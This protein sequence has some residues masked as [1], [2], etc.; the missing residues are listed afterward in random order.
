VRSALERRESRGAHVRDDYPA[1]DSILSRVNVVIR[2]RAGALQTICVPRVEP[3]EALKHLVPEG[4]E[5]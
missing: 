3:P 5:A 2:G 1:A 4:V